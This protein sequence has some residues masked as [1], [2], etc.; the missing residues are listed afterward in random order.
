MIHLTMYAASLLLIVVGVCGVI[1]LD[2]GEFS[3]GLCQFEVCRSSSI[4]RW[5]TCQSKLA[6]DEVLA[7]L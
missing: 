4:R 6:V 7:G 3:L 2:R 5:S 1:S